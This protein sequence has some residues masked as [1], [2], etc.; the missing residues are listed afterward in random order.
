MLQLFIFN[1]YTKV[2]AM[3]ATQLDSVWTQS[4]QAIFNGYKNFFNQLAKEIQP[5]LQQLQEIDE[6]L[7]LSI[8]LTSDN[9]LEDNVTRFF[10]DT[11]SSDHPFDSSF[12]TFLES[13][14]HSI[15]FNFSEL[16]TQ[17]QNLLREVHEKISKVAESINAPGNDCKVE[18]YSDTTNVTLFVSFNGE[19]YSF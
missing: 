19:Q 10:F 16:P 15:E 11:S 5:L 14:S 12:D 17:A 2:K 18:I 1:K 13:L 6:S 7:I 4:A 9:Y 8:E 3:N